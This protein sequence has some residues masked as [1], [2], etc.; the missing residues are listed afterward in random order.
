MH[1]KSIAYKGFII[2]QFLMLH[3][4][5]ELNDNDLVSMSWLIV[6]CKVNIVII[7][8]FLVEGELRLDTNYIDLIG[9]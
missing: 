5:G 7:L 9:H 6:Y 1:K 4:Y 2:F 8:E 3:C